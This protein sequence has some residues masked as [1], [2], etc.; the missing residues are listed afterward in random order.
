MPGL[1]SD[2]RVG[3]KRALQLAAGIEASRTQLAKKARTRGYLPLSATELVYELAYLRVFV[4][5]EVFLQETF[6]RYLCGYRAAHGQ[7]VPLSGTYFGTLASAHAAVLGH[8]QYLLW[9]N[10]T[11]VVN[12]AK[13]F[14]LNSQHEIVV[15]SATAPLERFAAIRHRIA[16]AQEHARRE[17]D[18]ATMTLAGK[19]YSGGRPGRFLRDWVPG[20]VPPVR[21]LEAISS[22]LEGLAS[23]VTP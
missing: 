15:G 10:P 9:H 5:W 20:A 22:Q 19:R 6:I 14:L 2:F 7:E 1:A 4:A 3:N 17:F 8:R 12:R 13:G 18:N 23:Q 16:H 11:T 21:W